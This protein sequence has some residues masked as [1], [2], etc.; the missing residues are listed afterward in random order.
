[1]LGLRTQETK[2]FEAFF[3]L[4]QKKA[5][6][7]ECVFFLDTGDG[8]SFENDLMECENLQGWL[9]PLSRADEFGKIWGNNE[10]DDEWVEFFCWV[11]WVSHK[12]EIDVRFVFDL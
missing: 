2:K 11:E 12:E 10:E 5:N 6:E 7:K 9:V 4:V 3:E 8:N 1:M